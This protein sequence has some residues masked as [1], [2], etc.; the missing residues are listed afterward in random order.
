M[1]GACGENAADLPAFG[2]L[3]ALKISMI[4]LDIRTLGFIAML[5]SILLALGLQ[6]VN[7]VIVRDAAFRLWTIGATV[8]GIGFVLL[9][10][11][12]LIPDLFSIVIANTLLVAGAS[13]Q[14]LGNRVFQ[15]RPR[16]F[17]WYGWLI[18]ATAILFVVFTYLT[19]NLAARIVIVSAVLSALHFSSAFVLLRPLSIQDKLLCLFVAGAF[20]MLATFLGGRAVANLFM[21]PIDPDFM[22]SSSMIQTFTFVLMIGLNLALGIGLPLLLL[23]RTQALL[24][25]SEERYRTLI[26]WSPEPMGV[27]D[28]RA[29]IYVNP[30][31][32]RM[33]GARSAQEVLARSLMSLVHPDCRQLASERMKA[34]IENSVI[35]PLSEQKYLKLDGSVIDV[36]VQSIGIVFDGRPAVQVAMTDITERKFLQDQIQQLAFHDPLTGLPNRRLFCDRLSQAMAANKRN[37]CFGALM[38]LDLDN[39]KPLNDTQGHEVGDKLLVEAA[40]RLTQCVRQVDTVARFGGDE[41]VVLISELE[42]DHERSAAD[43]TLIAEKIRA[44]LSQP[45]ILNIGRDAAEGAISLEHR[46]SASIGLTLFSGHEAS[47]DE[48]LKAAD[49]AMFEAKKSGRNQINLA[50]AMR[51]FAGVTEKAGADFMHLVWHKAYASG[52]AIIDAQHRSLFVTADALLNAHLS[53]QSDSD[54]GK[55]IDQLIHDA[56]AHFADEEALLRAAGFPGAA[57]HAASHGQLVER[58][59]LLIGQ[60][61]AGTLATG[62]LFEFLAH[63]LVARHM[64]NEDRAYFSYLAADGPHRPSTGDL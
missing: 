46:C 48:I 25:V 8:S 13:G 43:A 34:T 28:G 20:L 57:E 17:A 22:L 30:A 45:Y 2:L 24:M 36:E 52:N 50:P 5:S 53:G 58:A 61:K 55:L 7:R 54:V 37:A 11:R 59:G 47:Q 4:S 42:T 33:F 31:A 60:F 26:E 51:L 49:E 1:L 27:T 9:A 32:V 6:F 35:N 62:E 29:L 12:G 64:L 3:F 38:F 56:V 14:Y 63:D 21:G 40:A 10:L 18:G 15:G 41:F 16:E 23:G 39:F 19:P 44:A